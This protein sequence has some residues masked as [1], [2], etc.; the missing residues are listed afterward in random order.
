MRYLLLIAALPCILHQ[1]VDAI[2]YVSTC[3]ECHANAKCQDSRSTDPKPKYCQCNSGYI[4]NGTFCE[5]MTCDNANPCHKN[6]ICTTI[7]PTNMK[8]TCKS[9]YNGD[10][11]HC[12][13]VNECASPSTYQC[14]QNATCSNTEGSYMCVCNTMFLGNG[15]YCEAKTCENSKPCGPNS[16][17]SL[18]NGSFH[19]SCTSGYTGGLACTDVDECALNLDNCHENAT[20]SNTQGF[21]SCICNSMYLGNGTYC[22]AKTCENSK[23]CGPN[24][25]CSIINGSFHCACKAGFTGGLA[26]ADVDECSDASSN[27][28]H[29]KGLCTNTEGSYTCS[30]KP[31]YQGNGTLCEDINECT[32]N[33][34]N[35]H[36]NATCVNSEGSYSC[37]CNSM[38]LGNGTFCKEKTCENSKPCGTNSDC[39]IIKESF[40]CACQAGFTGGLACTDVD[41]CTTNTHTCHANATCTNTVGSYSC[42]CNSMYF[43][44]GTHC[45]EKTCENSKPCGPNSECSIKDESFHCSCKDGFTGGLAC[46]DINE[47]TSDV[48]NCHANATCV[49]SEGSYSCKCNSMYLGNGIFCEVKTCENSNPCGAN[50]DCSV[51]DGTFHCSCKPGFSGNLACIGFCETTSLTV[52]GEDYIF[53]GSSFGNI[54][55]SNEKCSSG[56]AKASITCSKE[57]EKFSFNETSFHLVP[58][59][60]TLSSVAAQVNWETAEARVLEEGV[61][62]L[63]VLVSSGESLAAEDRTAF[64]KIINISSSSLANKT[65]VVTVQTLREIVVAANSIAESFKVAQEQAAPKTKI[66]QTLVQEAQVMT[67]ALHVFA[68][69]VS[70]SNSSVV[71][72]TTNIRAEVTTNLPADKLEYHYSSE[73]VKLSVPKEAIDQAK[74]QTSKDRLVV[75]EYT[76]NTL[77]QTS[78][79]IDRV[80]TVELGVNVKVKDLKT[81]LKFSSTKTNSEV[82]TTIPIPGKTQSLKSYPKCTFYVPKN[83]TFSTK[84]CCLVGNLTHP[85]CRCDHMTS[86]AILMEHEV[87][88]DDIVLSVV[89]TTGCVISVIGLI[90]TVG[91]NLTDKKTGARTSRQRTIIVFVHICITLLA[92]YLVFLVGVPR[93]ENR[94]ACTAVSALLHYLLLTTWCWTTVYSY[95]MYRSLAV[96]STEFDRN[97][98]KKSSVF[99]Y[100]LPLV[101]VIV[102]LFSNLTTKQTEPTGSNYCDGEG[103]QRQDQGIGQNLASYR[104]KNMCWI[105]G[106]SLKFGFLVPAGILLLMNYIF[107]TFVIYS[108][109]TRRQRMRAHTNRRSNAREMTAAASMAT[110]LGLTWIFGYL[111]LASTDEIYRA[112]LAWLFT[113][114]NVMQGFILFIFTMIR[115]AELREKIYESLKSHFTPLSFDM[116]SKMKVIKQ[117]K[118]YVVNS[119]SNSNDETPSTTESTANIYKWSK[120]SVATQET[121]VIEENNESTLDKRESVVESKLEQ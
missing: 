62:K 4:G 102:T 60:E 21:H 82:G 34:H 108:L 45:E 81:P 41:E 22:E 35:C 48:H 90:I 27:N 68:A 121:C 86:F 72:E 83:L 59:N 109:A 87:V 96:V 58:C 38:Y 66:N 17:C 15:T 20:C 73:H 76:G 75:L 89:T 111:M 84:G 114:T 57:N 19:C 49:N 37:I 63:N 11:Y 69:K 100:G 105:T 97:F 61:S 50:S 18:Q 104:S 113:I 117:G 47:C 78:E 120:N 71:V 110:T 92:V 6:A 77:F 115:R 12:I 7:A 8:C 118:K 39:S 119:S 36:A 65:D 64:I 116:T 51:K 107:F 44:N 13:D 94:D 2:V 16:V 80:I 79:K 52:D 67:E 5:A 85:T 33:V 101:A 106:N 31:G 112:V 9:G 56:R 55:F 91:L 32:T 46:T 40:H 103:P 25:I 26:C 29:Q 10:G 95:V 54:V 98:L 28:C 23:P 30:C 43:G 93:T 70:L 99:A 88:D 3:T 74:S 53:N 14:H 42:T 1:S 24:S